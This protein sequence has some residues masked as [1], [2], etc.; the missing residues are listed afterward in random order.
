MSDS[1]IEERFERFVRVLETM[2][3]ERVRQRILDVMLRAGK[4]EEERITDEWYAALSPEE[5]AEIEAARAA[6]SEAA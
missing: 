4:E 1:T 5:L 6:E 2:E 3:G